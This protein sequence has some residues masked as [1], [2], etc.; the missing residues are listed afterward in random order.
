MAFW[1]FKSQNLESH[2]G[3]RTPSFTSEVRYL[4]RSTTSIFGY[5]I[6]IQNLKGLKF[7]L[8]TAMLI[9]ALLQLHLFC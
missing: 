7:S 3:I 4:S 6:D 5:F 8:C 2:S 9:E 1:A